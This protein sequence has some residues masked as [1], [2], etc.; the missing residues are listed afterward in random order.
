MF[1]DGFFS[2]IRLTLEELSLVK[3]LESFNLELSANVLQFVNLLHFV[4]YFF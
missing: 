2:R 1:R 4:F 3:P